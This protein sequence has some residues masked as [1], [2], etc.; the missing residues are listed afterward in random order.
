MHVCTKSFL[1]TTTNSLC[2]CTHLANKA[3]SDSDSYF[4]F[5]MINHFAWSS[6]IYC[7]L[8]Y[9][10][11]SRGWIKKKQELRMEWLFLPVGLPL[12]GLVWT[13]R[14]QLQGNNLSPGWTRE[15]EP[16]SNS[17]SSAIAQVSSWTAFLR[18]VGETG[19]AEELWDTRETSS[20]DT[21][22]G[23]LADEGKD[24]KMINIRCLLCQRPWLWLN[25]DDWIMKTL[26]F[27]Y[28]THV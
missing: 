14:Q 21:L 19:Q 23:L 25:D 8:L 5:N 16:C 9:E 11:N 15:R 1:K 12:V 20:A 18:P 26:L 10:V 13:D 22:T 4:I 6:F 17:G 27:I 3:D 2:V 28:C 24:K 7:S